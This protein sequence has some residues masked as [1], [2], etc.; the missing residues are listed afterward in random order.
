MSKTLIIG[1]PKITSYIGNNTSNSVKNF[2]YVDPKTHF[3]L[4]FKNGMVFAFYPN[5][6]ESVHLTHWEF[7]EAEDVLRKKDWNYFT[8][9]EFFNCF[10]QL[11][12]KTK[13]KMAS[14]QVIPSAGKLYFN[15]AT[16]Q[17]ERVLLV[18]EG[19]LIWTSRHKQQARPYGRTSFR[20]ATNE[21]VNNYL[22]EAG[23]NAVKV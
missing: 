3:V 2:G 22:R 13:K 21:E 16:T 9:E 19:R 12:I 7:S 10:P 5:T 23:D 18:Q 11:K 14:A 6:G 8:E 4:E 15:V 1:G 17:V 20:L